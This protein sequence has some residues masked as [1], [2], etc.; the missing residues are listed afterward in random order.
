VIEKN[1]ARERAKKK[2]STSN[3]KNSSLLSFVLQS[4]SLTR[5]LKSPQAVLSAVIS[6]DVFFFSWKAKS[7]EAQRRFFR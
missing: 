7:K 1:G 4:A 6:S 3:K 2:K 5:K